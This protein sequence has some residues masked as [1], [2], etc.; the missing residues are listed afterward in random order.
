MTVV[1]LVTRQGRGV[2]GLRWVAAAIDWLLCSLTIFLPTTMMDAGA[3]RSTLTLW[4]LAVALYF[5][6]S[7]A[8]FGRT[9]GKWAVGLRVVDAE[10]NAPGWGRSI[11][12]NLL[13]VIEASPL[14]GPF[15]GGVV[16]LI[17]K[18]QQRLGDMLAGTYVISDQEV[19]KV[20]AATGDDPDLSLCENC[21]TPYRLSTYRADADR[22]FCAG[23]KNELK[24]PEQVGDDR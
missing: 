5:A 18:R 19:L 12:R 6:G 21:G 8:V 24:R 1:E 14:T 13:R 4:L 11:I 23:C 2:L 16:A 17:S 22:I 7:E 15:V 20:E 9:L 10:G 3:W